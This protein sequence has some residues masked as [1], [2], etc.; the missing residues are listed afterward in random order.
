MAVRGKSWGSCRAAAAAPS[1]GGGRSTEA[2]QNCSMDAL[3]ASIMAVSLPTIQKRE[4][5]S[6][7]DTGTCQRCCEKRQLAIWNH[8]ALAQLNGISNVSKDVPEDEQQ[9]LSV[10]NICRMSP[11]RDTG[12]DSDE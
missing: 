5:Q 1:V 8:L 7:P 9:A 2:A 12:R 10:V 6:Q 4:G 3:A 11:E